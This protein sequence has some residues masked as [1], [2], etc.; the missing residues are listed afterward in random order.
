MH[1]FRVWAPGKQRVDLVS[2]ESRAPMTELE[3]GWWEGADA[4]AGP[5]TRYGFAIEGGETRPDPRSASQPDGVLGLSE[6]V[7]HELHSWTD[8]RWN[9]LSLS[10][11]VLYELHVGTFSPAGTFD[12]VIDHLPHLVALGVDGI[13]LMPVAEFSGNRGWGYDGVDFFAPHHCWVQ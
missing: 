6:V 12:G 13:E 9:G 3:G 1:R 7:D 4:A 5:G 10:R 8:A 11:L 2:G